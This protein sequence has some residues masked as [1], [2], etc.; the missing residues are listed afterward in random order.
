MSATNFDEFVS[1]A[2]NETM[3]KILGTTTWKSVNFFFD[4]KRAAREPE[5]FAAILDKVFGLT[6]KVLQKK[7]AETLLSQVGAAQ[8]STSLD[9][10]Q[11]LRLAR[12]KFPSTA[13]L[14]QLN[15]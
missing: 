3:S 2:V 5:A 14:G 4:T 12:A 8:P 1:Q 10:R 13:V 6:S 7:I 11:I 15:P 9:F